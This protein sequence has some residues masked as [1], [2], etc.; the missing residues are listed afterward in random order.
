MQKDFEVTRTSD[1]QVGHS[2]QSQRVWHN[3]LHSKPNNIRDVDRLT[4]LDMNPML[5]GI[6]LKSYVDTETKRKLE[7]ICSENMFSMKVE[8]N[9]HELT[10]SI[11]Y[12]KML[13]QAID[14]GVIALSDKDEKELK[15]K[16]VLPPCRYNSSIID[17][18]NKL[19]FSLGQGKEETIMQRLIVGFKKEYKLR[20][21]WQVRIWINPNKLVGSAVLQ[22]KEPVIWFTKNKI[23]PLLRKVVIN[24]FDIN[25]DLGVAI[26]DIAG[27]DEKYNQWTV[28]QFET[29]KYLNNLLK[30]HD[31]QKTDINFG[32]DILGVNNVLAIYSKTH[33]LLE[34]GKNSYISS[35][36]IQ[37]LAEKGVSVSRLEFRCY[38]E[39]EVKTFLENDT[40]IDDSFTIYVY[41][42]DKQGTRKRKRLK[43]LL[44]KTLKGA[45]QK[46]LDFALIN[47]NIVNNTLN[48]EQ[49][50]KTEFSRFKRF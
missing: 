13:Q 31:D 22:N 34:K 28:G 4:E 16:K 37:A 43:D 19:D 35:K 18:N 10:Y 45:S 1:L 3:V 9:T 48:C 23:L 21:R 11:D 2:L 25:V 8:K 42:R 49:I 32:S 44:N 40:Y 15:E 41:Y 5:D 7:E 33:E 17:E 29:T 38:N 14:N 50:H 47:D 6:K 24:Q 12:R 39:F 36:E 20:E 27:Y 30:H 46:I 26:E